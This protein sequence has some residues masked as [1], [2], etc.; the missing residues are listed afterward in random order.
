MTTHSKVGASSAKRW[1]ACPGSVR[2]SEGIESKSSKFSIEGTQ[3]HALAEQWLTA[4]E[5]PV[6]ADQ[7][8]AENVRVYVDW[9][10]AQMETP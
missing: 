10:S 9:V 1:M 8:M 6:N 4:G 2:L 5:C 7:E 3:A